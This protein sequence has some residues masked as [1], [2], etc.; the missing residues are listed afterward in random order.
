MDTPSPSMR[1]L[2]R[3]LLAASQPAS[4][5][6]AQAA[7]LVFDKLRMT[8]T[9]FA[10]AEGYALLLRRA[11]VLAGA[12]SPSLQSVKVGGEGRL[13]RLEQLG[14]DRRTGAEGAAG[15]AAVAIMSHLLGLLVTFIGEPFTLRLVR[16][17]WPDMSRD[18]E[19][20]RTEPD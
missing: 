12:E 18:E 17:A 11:W 1:I 13:E 4:D 15:E 10:G 7:V 2:A 16:E 8:L 3:R 9:T 14:A 6:Y 5:Q 19:H 20:S